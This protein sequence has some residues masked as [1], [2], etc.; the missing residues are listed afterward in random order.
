[1]KHVL[2]CRR[3][4]NC[5]RVVMVSLIHSVSLCY[6]VFFRRIVYVDKLKGMHAVPH[7]NSE[8]LHVTI[9]LNLMLTYFSPCAVVLLGLFVAERLFISIYVIMADARCGCLSTSDLG[10]ACVVKVLSMRRH[11][12]IICLLHFKPIYYEALLVNNTK[13][14]C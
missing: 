13:W 1:L 6:A 4:L 3:V 12:R 5:R 2:T 9:L 7:A 11:Q 10:R 14:R 8:F